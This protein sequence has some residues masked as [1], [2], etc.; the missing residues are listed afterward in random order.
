MYATNLYPIL[1]LKRL[2]HVPRVMNECLWNVFQLWHPHLDVRSVRV[3]FSRL[4]HRVEVQNFASPNAGT[5]SPTTIVRL[6][7]VVDQFLFKVVGTIAPILFQ[8]Q[9]EVASG[10]HTT[11]IRHEPSLIH[12]SH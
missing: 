9:A 6:D 2:Y 11:S 12:L 5:A 1:L 4:N 3:E 10:N 8:I 7:I